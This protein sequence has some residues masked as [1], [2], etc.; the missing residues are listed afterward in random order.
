MLTLLDLKLPC[1]FNDNPVFAH[2][3]PDPVMTYIDTDLFQF[4][5]HPR[6]AIVAKA[7]TRLFFDMGQNDHV[8]ALPAAGRAAAYGPQP[9]RADVHDLTQPLGWERP[10]MFFDKFGPPGFWLAKT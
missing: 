5:R 7:Q 9:A 3:T 1:S 6:P 4:L 10:T 8:C 2:Q